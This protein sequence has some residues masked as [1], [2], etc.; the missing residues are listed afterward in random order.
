M[1]GG[2][3]CKLGVVRPVNDVVRMWAGDRLDTHC[4]GADWHAGA[5]QL[6]KQ[7][8]VKHG[9]TKRFQGQQMFTITYG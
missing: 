5:Q 7:V 1:G 6:I 3:V 9:R 8:T 2:L 4:V